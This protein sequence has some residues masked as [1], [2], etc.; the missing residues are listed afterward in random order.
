MLRKPWKF[1]FSERAPDIPANIQQEQQEQQEQQQIRSK[2]P[3]PARSLVAMDRRAA[4]SQSG[5]RAMVL[6][7]MLVALMATMAASARLNDEAAV[8]TSRPAINDH[9]ARIALFDSL[10]EKY[11]DRLLAKNPA[12]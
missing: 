7:A 12:E 2:Y 6:V 3:S 4:A 9:A 8:M 11:V 5:C 1:Y 10:V